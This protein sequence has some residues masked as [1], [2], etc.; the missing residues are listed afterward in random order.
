MTDGLR[1]EVRR[2]ANGHVCALLTLSLSH[3]GERGLS[4][5]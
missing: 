1:G 5:A 4:P 2:L 3:G